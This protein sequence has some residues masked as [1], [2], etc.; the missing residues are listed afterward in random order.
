MTRILPRTLPKVRDQVVRHLTDPAGSLPVTM[1]RHWGPDSARQAADHLDHAALYWAT[2]DMTALAMSAGT[3]LTET[4]WATA[5]RPSACGLIV[6]DGGIGSI[7]YRGAPVPISATTWGPLPGGCGIVLWIPRTHIAAPD[8]PVREAIA[9][10]IPC[11]RFVLPVTADPIPPEGLPSAELAAITHALAASWLLMQQ[12]KL[13]GRVTQR[14]DKAVRRS[15]GRAGRES[16]EVT[17]IDLRHLYV[18][19]SADAGE[20][21]EGGR[22]YKHRWVVSG[23]WRDQPYG[24]NRQLRRRQWIP[25]YTKG[26]DGAPLLVTEKV[27]VW[28]R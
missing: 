10:L 9:P 27:N 6:W 16:P 13:V 20:G 22:L 18:P 14:P 15:Y 3:S 17:V 24:P 28:R 19:D 11:L 21:Q 4:R 2:G 7:D 1:D 5:D 26:P 25:S 23:H 12:P 8:Q